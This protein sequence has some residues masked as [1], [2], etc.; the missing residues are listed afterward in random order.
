MESINLGHESAFKILRS[1]EIESLVKDYDVLGGLADG[2]KIEVE[3]YLG[4]T[5]NST[6]KLVISPGFISRCFNKITGQA[7][8]LYV[9]D[10]LNRMNKAAIDV[11][12]HISYKEKI[13]L[14]QSMDRAAKGINRLQNSYKTSWLNKQTIVDKLGK[15]AKMHKK[16]AGL[17][18]EA[19]QNEYNKWRETQIS[20]SYN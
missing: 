4:G 7:D 14:H 5:L 12:N 16:T 10:K 20:I 13:R 18:N 19:I 11:L 1:R 9:L 6:S 15:F 17:V 8:S 3:D 2:E